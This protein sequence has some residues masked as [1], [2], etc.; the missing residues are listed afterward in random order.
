MIFC[1][2]TWAQRSQ[3]TSSK[4]VLSLHHVLS[5]DQSQIR[6]VWPKVA[7]A[8]H[9]SRQP[10]LELCETGVWILVLTQDGT[11][12]TESFKASGLQVLMGN[13]G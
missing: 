11:R 6:Q 13:T 4:L 10:L 12:N 7:L 8:V 9:P 1:V 2:T 3:D 5:G